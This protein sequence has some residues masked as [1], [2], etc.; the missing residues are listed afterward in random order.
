M[1]LQLL[2]YL[3]D[4]VDKSPLTL[5][6]AV[7]AAPGQV[8]SGRLVSASGRSYPIKDGIARFVDSVGASRES[9]DSFGDEWN[10]FN[11]DDFK[12]NWLAHTVQNTFGTVAAFEG[13]LVVDCGAGSGMQTKWIAEAG[14]RHVIAL[15]LSHSV[16]DVMQ[17]NLRGMPNVDI[18]QCSIDQPPLRTRAI[19]GI[20]ICH[21]VIQHT[22][23]VEGTARA[24][25]DLVGAGGEFVF[26][27]YPKNDLGLV[28]KL[29][30]A[31]YGSLRA[32]LSRCSFQVLLMYSR[33]M[34][35]LRF[36]PILGWFLEKAG[37]MVRGDV[38]AGPRWFF[39][40]YKSGVLN[41]YDC[42]GSHAFQHLKTDAEIRTLVAEL[43]PDSSLVL[44][45]DR[46]F[47]RPPPIGI[48]LRLIRG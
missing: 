18:V 36:V 13:K 16:D 2:D 43:Q 19:D 7:L 31:W 15:E 28:R 37:F 24:L 44:N 22:P 25:W 40:A 3:C 11:F 6:D 38:P 42:Y 35:A 41:T 27:C 14:A 12:A 48:A 29:R 39:R 4:P 10:H 1:N 30:L 8:R 33:A 9:V 47:L 34:A 45:A 23:S 46:Y 20:V 17:R 26:N 5:T 21:N 32:V